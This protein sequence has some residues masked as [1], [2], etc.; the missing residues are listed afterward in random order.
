MPLAEGSPRCP[1]RRLGK[2][3]SD[4]ILARMAGF[5]KRW[6]AG[7]DGGGRS[8]AARVAALERELAEAARELAENRWLMS[9]WQEELKRARGGTGQHVDD[10]VRAKLGW[11]IRDIGEPL[12]ELAS[13][14]PPAPGTA[15]ARRAFDGLAGALA[16]YGVAVDG[17]VGEVVP[18][19]EGR[20]EVAGANIAAGTPVRTLRPG[21][22]VGDDWVVKRRVA[23]NG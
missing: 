12:A 22:R 21:V 8:D 3:A 6:L 20:H 16:P 7:G 11:F 4:G 17:A 18:F 23:R 19:D 15:A 9:Q 10:A 13:S 2:R 1:R 5:L 14:L